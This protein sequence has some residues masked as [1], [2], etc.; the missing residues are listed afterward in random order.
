MQHLHVCLRTVGVILHH[1]KYTPDGDSAATSLDSYNLKVFLKTLSGQL[2]DHPVVHQRDRARKRFTPLD[3]MFPVG[4]VR[5][6]HPVPTPGRVSGGYSQWRPMS[7]ARYPLATR[8]LPNGVTT[9][10]YFRKQDTKINQP[11]NSPDCNPVKKNFGAIWGMQFV[12]SI[13]FVGSVWFATGSAGWMGR[14][15][16]RMPTTLSGQYALGA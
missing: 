13:T 15:T 7:R 3:A 14:Y 1:E 5:C 4:R 8:L 9:V 10:T 2:S 16:S 6:H 12:G 11:D